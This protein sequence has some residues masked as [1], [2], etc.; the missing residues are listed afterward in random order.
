MERKNRRAMKKTHACDY[1]FGFRA[2]RVVLGECSGRG[3]A[4]DQRRSLPQAQIARRQP[5]PAPPQA[6]SVQAP[7]RGSRGRLGTALPAPRPY[8]SAWQNLSSARR[9][10]PS[11]P[12]STD[13][14]AFFAINLGASRHYPKAKTVSYLRWRNTTTGFASI[15]CPARNSA[16]QTPVIQ[17]TY[18]LDSSVY[19]EVVAR[20]PGRR[21]RKLGRFAMARTIPQQEDDI[22]TT[23]FVLSLLAG[24]WVLATDSMISGLRA[25]Q[26]HRWMAGQGIFGSWLPTKNLFG[27]LL[28]PLFS[29]SAPLR[30]AGPSP[31]LGR[32]DCG[33]FRTGFFVR[34]GRNSRRRPRRYGRHHR[35]RLIMQK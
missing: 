21:A 29:V 33:G 28:W 7:M 6:Q 1:V 20:S 14:A 25:D 24:L 17:L 18:F 9:R 5:M 35:Y 22:P 27:P 32:A 11:S 2:R 13:A 8:A 16:S 26:I 31:R 19:A 4:P 10:L 12:R 30:Q 3:K 15:L 23:A 34:S